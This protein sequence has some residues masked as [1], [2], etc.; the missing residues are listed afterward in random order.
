MDKEFKI[1]MSIMLAVVIFF[2]G[3]AAGGAYVLRELSIN[4]T[5]TSYIVNYEGHLYEYEKED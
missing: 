4:Q 5:D 1:I 2:I 3:A